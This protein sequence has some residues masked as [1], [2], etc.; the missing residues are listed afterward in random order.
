MDRKALRE[1][2]NA[3]I[4][5]ARAESLAWRE[6][7]KSMVSDALACRAVIAARR[8]SE[9]NMT[10]A[11]ETA[12]AEVAVR[13][14]ISDAAARINKMEREARETRAMESWFYQL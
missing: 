13:K 12:R 4:A 8:V 10:K 7:D 1:L 2:E 6:R 9:E 5:A 14:V 11:A 3:R